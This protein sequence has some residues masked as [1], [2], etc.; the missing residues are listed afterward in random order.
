MKKLKRTVAIAAAAGT[1]FGSAFGLAACGQNN[2][3]KVENPNETFQAQIA[4]L[5]NKLDKYEAAL[6]KLESSNNKDAEKAEKLQK[7]I[8]RLTVQYSLANTFTSRYNEVNTHLTSA[9]SVSDWSTYY[10]NPNGDYAWDIPNAEQGK[11]FIYKTGDLQFLNENGTEQAQPVNVDDYLQHQWKNTTQNELVKTD[12]NTYTFK[13]NNEQTSFTVN[14]EGYITYVQVVANDGK[15]EYS[16]RKIAK[17]EYE[18]A[19]NNIKSKIKLVG[20]CEKIEEVLNQ[21]FNTKYLS[22]DS[23]CFMYGEDAKL[24]MLIDNNKAIQCQTTDSSKQ[25]ILTENGKETSALN[26][27]NKGYSFREEETK[28]LAPKDYGDNI[29]SFYNNSKFT[30]EF[31]KENNTYVIKSY[32]NTGNYFDLLSLTLNE[33]GLVSQMMF[34]YP[35]NDDVKVYYDVKQLTKA[36]FE[37]EF[38]KL[39]TEMDEFVEEHS[40]ESTL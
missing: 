23:T 29:K 40:N 34:E 33:D 37:K 16:V 32:D 9:Q 27:D 1:L 20:K 3:P 36:Q 24:K 31:D 17:L 28:T 12:G 7:E 38:N 14:D 13:N 8:D 10:S 35:Q 30:I 21:T 19:A 26:V 6:E 18:S 11:T 4:D 22:M 2:Q 5:Q 25:Y 39:Q 15:V